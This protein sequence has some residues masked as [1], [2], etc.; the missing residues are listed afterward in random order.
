MMNGLEI[1]LNWPE[2]NEWMNDLINVQINGWMD[3]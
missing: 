1:N 2:M 3:G